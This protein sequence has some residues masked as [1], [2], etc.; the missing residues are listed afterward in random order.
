MAR[1]YCIGFETNSV[2]NGVEANSITWNTNAGAM[3]IQTGTVR[4]GTY[5]LE[6]IASGSGDYFDF[7]LST[8]HVQFIRMYFRIHVAT[9]AQV[10]IMSCLDSTLAKTIGQ[11]SLN[12][13][14]TLDLQ[15]YNTSGVLTKIGSSSSALT[16][17]TWYMVELKCDDTGGSTST[18]IE[19][20]LNGSVFATGTENINTNAGLPSGFGCI[21]N[22]SQTPSATGTFF[23]DDVAVNDSTG[24]SQTSYPGTGNIVRV[25]PNATGDVNTWATQTGGTAGSVNNYTRVN[26][27]TPN[28]ATT[29]NG[30]TVLGQEDL[31]K[32]TDPAIGSGTV[33]VVQVIARYRNNTV[34]LTTAFK[35]ECEKAPAGTIAQ[36]SSI[37]PDGTTWKTAPSSL[38]LVLY[39]DPDGAAWT[40]TTL[41]TMQ[42]G[43]KITTAHTNAID[44]TTIWAYVDYV[45]AAAAN[46]AAIGYKSLLGVGF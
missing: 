15:Y 18:V 13:N 26:E 2:T 5:A 16:V 23:F 30:S 38:T 1:Q 32:C 24:S 10:D 36:S 40:E 11:I 29:F 6:D 37:D 22:I 20:R 17:D 44:V 28:D 45:P 34:D 19:G 35:I 21:G 7:L 8:D 41:A 12:T 14:N 33:S 39:N 27:T 42:I 25:T 46:N 31:F 4:T 3:S 43:Y 9:G